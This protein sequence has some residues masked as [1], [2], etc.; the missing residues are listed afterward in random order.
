MTEEDSEDC[1][2][3]DHEKSELEYITSFDG[4]LYTFVS[5]SSDEP[6]DV[7]FDD[8]RLTLFTAVLLY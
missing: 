2:L 1:T 5:N 7:F 6:K 8:L 3:T 4:Y